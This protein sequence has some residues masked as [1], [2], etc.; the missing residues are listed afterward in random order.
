[1]AQVFSNRF[2]LLVKAALLCLLPVVIIGVYAWRTEIGLL[3]T[4]NT[5]M[6][7][8]L[9]F[10]HKHHVL[11]DGI[12][13]RYCHADVETSAHAGL[14]PLSTCMTCHSQLYSDAPVLQPLRTAWAEKKP[15]HW[16]RINTLPDFVYFNHSIHIAKGIGCSSCH[17]QVQHMPRTWRAASLE[18]KWCLDCHRGPEK[19]L[20][21]QSE[22]FDM[23]WRPPADQAAIGAR[24][25]KQYHIDKPLLI[26]CSTCHR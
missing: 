20:R 22:I 5:P 25:L 4:V 12:D 18:M 8:P 10:S 26:E 15:I 21:P 24:L 2:G 6:K 11:D 19:A 3:P 23:T 17:G 13:C 16:I 9:P 7:Q 1:M 14:P